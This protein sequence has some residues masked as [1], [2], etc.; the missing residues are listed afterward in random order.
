MVTGTA[1]YHKYP[2]M[3]VLM[4]TLQNDP[5]TIDTGAEDKDQYGKNYGRTIRKMIADCLQK[6]PSKRPTATELLRHPFFKKSKDKKFLQ[7]SLLTVAPSIETRVQKAAKRQ[8]ASGKLH[9]TVSGEWVWS[10]DDEDEEG[11]GNRKNMR[12]HSSAHETGGDTTAAPED[13]EKGPVH[14]AG[15]RPSEP[16]LSSP[17]VP[18]QL[19]HQSSLPIDE[20]GRMDG[21]EDTPVNLVLRMR[22]GPVQL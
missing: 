7:Q 4:L 21:K 17:F 8:P 2:P 16:M 3:K 14:S 9:R 13:N 6:D 12:R 18:Q 19:V 20:N 10:S 22:W 11:L 1:P 5:P 15:R